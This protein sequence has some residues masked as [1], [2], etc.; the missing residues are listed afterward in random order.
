MRKKKK[1]FG[2][3]NCLVEPIYP[4]DDYYWSTMCKIKLVTIIEICIPPTPHLQPYLIYAHL[5]SLLQSNIDILE[6]HPSQNILL[7]PTSNVHH[8][9]KSLQIQFITNI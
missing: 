7:Y 6:T 1:H 3:K 8:A 2:S 5:Y 9:N 4:L